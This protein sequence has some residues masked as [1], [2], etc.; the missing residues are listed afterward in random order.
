MVLLFFFKDY[1]YLHLVNSN[2]CH[3]QQNSFQIQNLHFPHQ[4]INFLIDLHQ[5]LH[6]ILLLNQFHS[7]HNHIPWKVSSNPFLMPFSNQLDVSCMKNSSICHKLNCSFV[8]L[9]L[10]IVLRKISFF[11][12]D[13]HVRIGVLSILL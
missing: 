9:L 7:S 6:Y 10:V 12:F 3:W 13:I 2:N 5:E 4:K 8:L 11:V 1:H